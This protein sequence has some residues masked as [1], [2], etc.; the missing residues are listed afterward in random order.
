MI[1]QDFSEKL[2]EIH[3]L[4]FSLLLQQCMIDDDTIDNMCTSTYEEA[5]EY[6]KDIGWLEKVNNRIYKILFREQ[7]N[8][9]D[10]QDGWLS[11]CQQYK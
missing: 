4:A 3:T 9:E 6:F 7:A 5:C 2:K 11:Q 10:A 1:V 8:L